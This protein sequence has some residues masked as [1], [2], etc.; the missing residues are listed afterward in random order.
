MSKIKKQLLEKRKAVR[1]TQCALN[2]AARE[3]K[4]RLQAKIQKLNREIREADSILVTKGQVN[5]TVSRKINRLVHQD[6][7]NLRKCCRY[8]NYLILLS[9]ICTC[10]AL[11]WLYNRVEEYHEDH[12]D[13]DDNGDHDDHDGDN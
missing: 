2:K 4:R 7:E 10:S 9:S 8:N 3:E 6:L 12:N 1:K 11:Y 5:K 13:N